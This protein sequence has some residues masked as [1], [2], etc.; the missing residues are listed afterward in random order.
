MSE[1]VLLSE[2]KDG[3]LLL[4]FNRPDRNNG[5]N[6]E[7]EE[8][9]FD[10]LGEACTNP[11]VKVIVITGAGRSFCPG[12]DMN[13]LAAASQGTPMTDGKRYPMIYARLIPKPVI[14]A[15]NGAC[16]GIGLIQAVAADVRFAAEGAKFTSS[17]ARRGLH[18]EHGV[19]WLLER[20]VGLGHTSDLLLSAR[21]LDAEEAEKLGLVNKVFPP[22]QLLEATLSYA[23][24]MAANCS[25][26][27]LATIK[28]QILGD[29]NRTIYESRRDALDLSISVSSEPDFKEGV[30]S[31]REKRL[32]N[33]SGIA[34]NSGVEKE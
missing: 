28:A 15:I 16:A 24:E 17:F 13:T 20:I 6:I 1:P 25:P 2:I 26:M 8:A 3:V 7:L 9:Y 18:A 21:V 19:A 32:P 5:W 12:L 34:R 10:A 29:Y 11:A 22:D 30:N 31:F 23:R 4:T 27:A 33:F 14:A